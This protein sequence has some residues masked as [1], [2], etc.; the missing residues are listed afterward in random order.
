MMFALVLLASS[1]VLR[2]DTSTVPPH[3]RW[4]YDRFVTTAKHLPVD[5]DCR[6]RVKQG[7][8]VYV[9]LMTEANLEALRRGEKY[10]IIQ[11]ASRGEL[12][13]EIGVPGTFAIVVWNDDDSQPALVA[14]RLALD[15]PGNPLNAPK[16][17]SP[18]RKWTVILLSVVGFLSILAWSGWQ[19][20]RAI[21]SSRIPDGP[22]SIPP[23]PDRDPD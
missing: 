12:R 4:R 10:R 3:H 23:T 16:T 18:E 21:T 2:D 8:H 15:F 11:T 5:V 17:L 1:V 7:A 22:G 20:L 9:E 6:F 14:L 13:Q 19:L